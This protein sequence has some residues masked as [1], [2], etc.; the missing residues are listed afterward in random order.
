MAGI[1]RYMNVLHL[2]TTEKSQW[3]VPEVS[4]ALAVPTSTTY[5]TMRE[6]MRVNLLS[7]GG[8]GLY[9][10]GPAFI[11]FDRRT[12]LTDPLTSKAA[13]LLVDIVH[14]AA[15]PCVALLARLYGETVMC[16]ADARSPGSA[17]HSS[18]ERG[19]PMP[20]TRG[21]TSKV[22]LAQL[23]TR[24]L[25][26]VL[27]PGASGLKADGDTDRFRQELARIRKAGFAIAH[28]EVDP[29]SVGIAVPIAVP[30]QELAGSVSL[31]LL[32]SDW[33]EAI[34]QRLVLLLVSSGA[35][36][37]AQLSSSGSA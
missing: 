25:N 9:R 5:R 18:Y 3:T 31:V 23:S 36:L 6:L 8:D 16:V 21:A 32:H 14:H 17:V 10:L 2:F 29:D 11:E 30:E 33:S 4:A 7:M 22:I 19:R 37:R 20:L 28:G 13:P 35:L 34:E 1:D 12:R 24:R 26:R 15:V 27:M